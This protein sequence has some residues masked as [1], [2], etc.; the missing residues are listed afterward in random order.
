[1]VTVKLARIAFLAALSSISAL[2]QSVPSKRPQITAI[3]HVAFY[4]TQPRATE[5]LYTQIIGLPSATP[6]EPN[7][8][9]R[10]VVGNQWI[11]YSPAP[12]A[13][14]NSRMDHVAFRTDDVEALRLRLASAGVGVP[15]K[16]QDLSDGGHSFLIRD[17]EGNRIE[18][19]QPPKS[20]RLAASLASLSGSG[21]CKARG[22]P[23]SAALTR[24]VVSSGGPSPL[25]MATSASA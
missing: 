19:V 7:Q 21:G 18:F 4:S 9:Q 8:T 25:S 14:A 15:Q 1:M 6:L 5:H 24:V 2:S 23:E 10:F 11:G 22:K 17:P 13:S 16:T 12:D 3:D 20:D